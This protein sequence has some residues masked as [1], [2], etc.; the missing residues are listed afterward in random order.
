MFGGHWLRFWPIHI[1][2]QMREEKFISIKY[3]RR[4]IYANF[5]RFFLAPPGISN[6][7]KWTKKLTLRRSLN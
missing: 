6:Q 3:T 7:R 1:G 4:Y 2:L 5:R